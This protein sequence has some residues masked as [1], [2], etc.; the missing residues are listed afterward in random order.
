MM[1][2]ALSLYALQHM[3]TGTQLYT[4]HATNYEITQANINL[5]RTHCPSRFV[6]VAHQAPAIPVAG[7]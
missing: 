3:I 1:T 4:L 7:T 6:P 5:A 2:P